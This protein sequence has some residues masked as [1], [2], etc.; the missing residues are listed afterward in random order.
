ME[1]KPC[2]ARFSRVTRQTEQFGARRAERV[3]CQLAARCEGCARVGSAK[4]G[5]QSGTKP[6]LFRCSVGPTFAATRPNTLTEQENRVCDS[7]FESSV[8]PM[9]PCCQQKG[10]THRLLPMWWSSGRAWIA[11][12]LRRRDSTP[13]Y[14]KNE[15]ANCLAVNALLQ[16]F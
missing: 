13:F 11:S 4:S 3:W 6:A 5:G 12:P 7:P 15:N 10:A 14:K 9:Y 8:D 2:V 16:R 1:K